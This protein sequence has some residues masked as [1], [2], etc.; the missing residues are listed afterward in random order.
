M[1]TKINI[2]TSTYPWFGNVPAFNDYGVSV[3]N[4]TFIINSF[5]FLQ[6]NKPRLHILYDN[7]WNIGFLLPY[8]SFTM[9]WINGLLQDKSVIGINNTL[10]YNKSKCKPC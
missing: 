6:K 5:A 3:N 7:H 4:S 2:K 9:F 8:G 10:F 1:I